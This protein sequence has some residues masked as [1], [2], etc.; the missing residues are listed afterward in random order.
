MLIVGVAMAAY[1]RYVLRPERLRK[2][3]ARVSLW[4]AFPL[5]TCILLIAVTGFLV[6]GLRI[7]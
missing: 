5:L 3:R 7:A 1:R 6:E 4:D 2:T